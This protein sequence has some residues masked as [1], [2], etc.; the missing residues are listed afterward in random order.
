MVDGCENWDERSDFHYMRDGFK[1]Y[2]I[3]GMLPKVYAAALQTCPTTILRSN[4]YTA[5]CGIWAC[6]EYT[7]EG[8]PE[9]TCEP[10]WGND[11]APHY[12]TNPKKVKSCKWKSCGITCCRRQLIWTR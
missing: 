5:A 12:G 10:E 6:C 9:Y 8:I 1:E 4:V 7:L 11:P 2:V 3:L